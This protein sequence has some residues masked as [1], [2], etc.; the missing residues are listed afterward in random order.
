MASKPATTS[1]QGARLGLRRLMDDVAAYAVPRGVPAAGTRYASD[2]DVPAANNGP[3]YSDE[4]V[5]PACVSL[6]M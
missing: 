5:R 2:D 3:G 6:F 4:L 1:G